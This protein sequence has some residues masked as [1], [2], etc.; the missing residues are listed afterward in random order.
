MDEQLILQTFSRFYKDRYKVYF[1]SAKKRDNAFFF[2]IKDKKDK[3][4]AIAGEISLINQFEGEFL[5]KGKLEAKGEKFSL[6]IA[7]LNHHNLTLLQEIFPH[8]TP[9]TAA[10]KKSFGTGD[11]LGIATA[12]HIQ[13]FKD[14]DIFPVL[15][16]Q[17]IRENT[18]T[19]R[20][21]QKVLDDAIWG[22][23]EAGY[24][25]PFGA[26]ADHIKK[27]EDLKE[28]VDCGYTMFTVDPSDFVR[29]DVQALTE[30]EKNKIYNKIPEKDELEK[31]YL[32][33]TY[34]IGGQKFHFDA[35]S[36]RD[37]ILTYFEALQHVVKCYRFLDDYKKGDFDFEV[38]VDETSLPTSPLAHIFI[39]QELHRKKVDFQNLALR[40][41]GDWQKGIDYIGDVDKFA[42]ELFLHARVAKTFGGYKLSLHSGSDKFSVYPIFAEKTQGL[43]HIKTAGT[44]WLEAVRV[45]A[46][47]NPSLYR[48]LHKFALDN[49]EKDRASYHVTTD[50]SRI[51]D[52]DKLSDGQLEDLLKKPD[53]R[54]LIH[55]TYGSILTAKNE[56]GDFLFRDQIYKTLFQYEE[57][58][59]KKVSS[60]IEKHLKLL[61]S[62]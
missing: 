49:F 51:P 57:E 16:Q 27:V 21:M 35:Q 59:Y 25:G 3:Y 62:S 42:R 39:V 31:L 5:G 46:K 61:L 45:I 2:I 50:L 18:R 15:A 53:S 38:S 1:A 22:C 13:A 6:R 48:K 56:T 10:L 8:L 20:S 26:D 30:E 19:G 4:L 55:I 23:F 32:D 52:V 7:Y 47:K 43:F 40:F 14:R 17:S 37:I 54:Q 36:L 12:A 29:D 41:I 33:K 34:T 28:A 9:S 60:H 24:E 44:S 58:H 11:R